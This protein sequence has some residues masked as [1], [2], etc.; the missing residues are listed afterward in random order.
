MKE[1][2]SSLL[3][4]RRHAVQTLPL[5]RPPSGAASFFRAGRYS[6]R[7]TCRPWRRNSDTPDRS[8]VGVDVGGTFTDAALIA[9]G[10]LY[11]AKVA[12]TPDDQSQGVIEAIELAL[13]QAGCDAS[14]IGRFAHGMTVGTNALLEERGARTAL[15][16]TEGFTDVIEIG[17]QARPE[18]YRLCRPKPAPLVPAPAALRRP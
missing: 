4:E 3:D 7:V 17:R 8:L 12:T 15:L 16:A 9:G 6:F 11:T 14:D 5:K 1:P 10:R 13:A 2:S 18:L